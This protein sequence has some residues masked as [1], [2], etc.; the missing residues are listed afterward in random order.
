M[1]AF[2]GHQV[3]VGLLTTVFF[4][5]SEHVKVAYF[6]PGRPGALLGGRGNV[7]GGQRPFQEAVEARGF[8]RELR[9]H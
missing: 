7:L 5:L 9:R 4:I 2:Q 3:P 8:S 6:G 1:A